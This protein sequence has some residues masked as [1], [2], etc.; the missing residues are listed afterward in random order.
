[1][2]SAGRKKWDLFEIKILGILGEEWL[3]QLCSVVR[4]SLFGARYS[5]CSSIDIHTYSHAL[6]HMQ[7][8]D[9]STMLTIPWINL[10]CNIQ[11]LTNNITI[12]FQLIAYFAHFQCK[13]NMR[14]REQ[15]A[16]TFSC[17]ILY[18]FCRIMFAERRHTRKKKQQK[19]HSFTHSLAHT[20]SHIL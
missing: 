20:H 13:R 18:S 19:F 8:I 5:R 16:Q 9:W 17:N 14:E 10:I 2:N 4:C 6:A 11:H 3:I 1:M 15:N 7:S 12:K